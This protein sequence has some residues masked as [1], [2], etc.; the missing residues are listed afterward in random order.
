MGVEHEKRKILALRLQCIDLY[1]KTP[2]SAKGIPVSS[3][4]TEIYATHL[5][6]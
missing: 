1:G 5:C 2:L 4:G 3:I 6:D